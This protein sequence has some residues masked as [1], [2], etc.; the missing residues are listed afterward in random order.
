MAVAYND[1]IAVNNMVQSFQ[2]LRKAGVETELHIYATG[3]HAFGGNIM[4]PPVPLVGDWSHRLE[5][6]MRYQRLLDPK[7]A[8]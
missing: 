3:G 8:P 2:A 4:K 1:N 7:K 6:W 5:A